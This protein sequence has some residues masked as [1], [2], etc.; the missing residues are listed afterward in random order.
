MAACTTQSKL[1][2]YSTTDRSL[3]FY[4]KLVDMV[5][6]K[7]GILNSEGYVPICSQLWMMI[8]DN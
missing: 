5:P 3:W 4:Y 7:Y 2:L 6:D 8:H 1:E